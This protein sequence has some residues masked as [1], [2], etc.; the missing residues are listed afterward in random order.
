MKIFS[1][2]NN[3]I[4]VKLKGNQAEDF[5]HSLSFNKPV[6]DTFEKSS[7]QSKEVGFSGFS[8]VAKNKLPVA[9]LEQLFEK[10]KMAIRGELEPKGKYD[11]FKT[12]IGPYDSINS[13]INNRDFHIE[14]TT[15]EE[16][17]DFC[18]DLLHEVSN[19]INMTMYN[20]R[21][22]A[23]KTNPNPLPEN[24]DQ[25]F[26]K[27]LEGIIDIYKKYQ[28][29]ID[30]GLCTSDKALPVVFDLAMDLIKGKTQKILIEGTEL[31]E[32]TKLNLKNTE[33]YSVFSNII[34]NAAKYSKNEGNIKIKFS[35]GKSLDNKPVLNFS[36]QDNGIGIPKDQIETVL[37]GIR[38]TNTGEIQG[39]GYGL[40]RVNKILEKV[41]SKVIIKSVEG[42]GTKITC[43]IPILV[44]PE[45]QI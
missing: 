14:G 36:V 29:F 31:L 33:I 39:T 28:L 16:R 5:K 42:K 41:N 7:A 25:I 32:N 26:E 6:K 44:V 18:R 15:Q 38:A 1:F 35:R 40:S 8:S 19:P 11:V 27:E 20:L 12:M 43:P 21:A 10:T 17:F 2:G 37:K 22:S 9:E 24:F 34:Q 3:N 30:S 23:K 45:G 4:K 13:K